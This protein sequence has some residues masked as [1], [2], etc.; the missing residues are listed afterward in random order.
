[1]IPFLYYIQFQILLVASRGGGAWERRQGLQL[2][3]KEINWGDFDEEDQRLS[4]VGELGTFWRYAEV[5][6]CEL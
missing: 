2:N 5:E 6:K 4:P 3:K 1:M